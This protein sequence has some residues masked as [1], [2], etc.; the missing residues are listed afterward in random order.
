MF[1]RKL[2]M[3]LKPN[4]AAE[5]T[6]TLDSQ[7]IPALRKQKGFREELVFIGPN[8]NE[9]FAISLWDAKEN[10]DAYNRDFYPEIAKTLAKVV[11]G[12]PQL[13]T[14]EVLASTLHNKTVGVTA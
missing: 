1:A 14:Y 11:E 2:T 13:H 3:Q 10:A 6:K 9:A 12:V 4:T 8:A 7:V 5:F